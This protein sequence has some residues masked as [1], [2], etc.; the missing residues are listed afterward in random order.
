MRPVELYTFAIGAQTWR[1]HNSVEATFS[2]GGN[3]FVAVAINREK[4]GNGEGPLD[5]TLPTS[6]AVPQSYIGSAPGQNATVTVQWLDRDDNPDSLRTIYKGI[7]KSVKLVDDGKKA[8]LHAESI[9]SSF[10][11]Q[12]PEDSFSPQCQAFLY[13]EHCTVSKASFSYSG[14]VTAVS[15]NT[16]TVDGLST[17]GA[18]WAL[19]GY[20]AYGTDYRQVLAQSGDVLTMILPFVTDITGETVTVYA[21]CDH[22]ASVCNSKFNNLVNHR[23]FPYVPTKNPFESGLK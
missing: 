3:D 21:G 8:Q 19:A 6:H 2:I 18:G 4:I 10:K 5:I 13:D 14:T 22:S 7:L 16:I 23:G 17:E 15:G 1:A 9:I 12:T 11:R 20:I